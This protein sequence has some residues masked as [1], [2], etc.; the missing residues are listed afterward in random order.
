MST[1]IK[2]SLVLVIAFL[3]GAGFYG[4]LSSLVENE[5]KN[6][7]PLTVGI[8]TNRPPFVYLDDDG[9][10]RGFSIELSQEIC[11]ILNRKCYFK[12]Y[13]IT[14]LVNAIRDREVD[15][16]L[17]ELPY[18]PKLMK[19]FAFSIVYYR[20]RSFFIS[21]GNRV[22]DLTFANAPNLKIGVR[23]NSR[24]L[25]FL[26]ETY[27]VR[28]SEI[29]SYPTYQD[30]ISALD[31]GEV[32][33]LFVGGVPGYKILTNPVGRTFFAVGFPE[34]T[35]QGLD[36]FRIIARK[37]D[38]ELIEQINQALFELYSNGKFHTLTSR[39]LPND[40]FSQTTYSWNPTRE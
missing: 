2:I 8:D 6:Q 27:A 29:R 14:T 26:Q 13:D 4:Y 23:N 33:V 21:T 15:I 22:N 3:I 7:T 32:D 11:K 19:D 5:L 10:F 9:K 30:M 35:T 31:A 38:H 12:T 1:K 39:Y 25:S 18:T 36:E 28:G 17:S 20:S 34:I 16:A 40:H 37:N 24:Q